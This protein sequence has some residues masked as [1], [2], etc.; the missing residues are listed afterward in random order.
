M[1][2]L[3]EIR[4]RLRAATHASPGPWQD[5]RKIIESYNAGQLWDA[6]FDSKGT[7]TAYV[8][9]ESEAVFIAQA[10]QDIA[11]LLTK[12][13]QL[14]TELAYVNNLLNTQ[15]VRLEQLS[16]ERYRES[17]ATK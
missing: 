9:G 8:D 17:E 1:T 15:T 5:G 14:T 11:D 10:P 6:V 12:I 13:D 16:S 4:A 7:I 2:N 3:N